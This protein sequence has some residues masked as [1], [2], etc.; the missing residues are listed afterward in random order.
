M[1]KIAKSLFLTILAL[2]ASMTLFAGD[3]KALTRTQIPVQVV[4]DLDNV[5]YPDVTSID[6]DNEKL[7]ISEFTVETAGQLKAIVQ[8]KIDSLTKG[9]IWVSTD[10]NGKQIIGDVSKFSG[11]QTEV[12]WFL[13][14]G[15]YYFHCECE[16]YPYQVNVALLFEKAKVEERIFSTSFSNSN[17]M[18]PEK[19]ALNYLTNENPNE[20]YSFTVKEK[21]TV[22]VEYS[23]DAAANK[24]S[25][26]GLCS[27]YDQY[28]LLLKEDTYT[29]SDKGM[30]SFDYLLEP[31]TY[32][33]KLSGM[34]GNTMLNLKYMVYNITLTA[35]TDGKWTKKAYKVDI[36]T[37]IDY[38][39]IAVLCYDVKDS[40]IDNDEL[41]SPSNKNYVPLEGESF[42]A[43]KSGVYSVRITDRNGYNTMAKIDI[44]NID[45]KK[46]TV[47]GVKDGEY[48]NKAIT[49]TWQ[50]TQSGINTK[51]TTLNGKAINDAKVDKN[52]K[53]TLKLNKEG[54]YVLKVYDNVGN[55]RE[56]TFYLDF[57]APTAGVENGKTY[58]ESVTLKFKDNLTGI[59]KITLDGAEIKYNSY[60]VYTNGEYEL[61]LWDNADNYRKIV[62]YI[63]K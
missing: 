11:E 28:G 35:D 20:Y 49:I 47:K 24:P 59:K 50:D 34:K 25:D 53:Y 37:S 29:S 52:G 43:T 2:G 6:Y 21:T 58:K 40:L 1:K 62:F 7:N 36:D 44:S 22:T 12:S 9:N 63:K 31:G 3:A 61:E 18:E 54:K 8:C 4:E 57:T 17:P 26:A 10:F 48:Y 27:L 46:P 39:S 41:W 38:K 60:Y 33:I 45:V 16:F 42:E 56:Y 19:I 30:K 55:Y 51:K 32:Y 13:E 14:K 15:K 23:F 5:P